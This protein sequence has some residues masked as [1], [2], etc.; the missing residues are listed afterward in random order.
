MGQVARRVP[1]LECGCVYCWCPFIV[2]NEVLPP[3]VRLVGV[4]MAPLG[5]EEG[6]LAGPCSIFVLEQQ[7]P[8][9]ISA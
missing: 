6:S 8:F 7:R 2:H 9:A 1:S 3:F 5:R 4:T